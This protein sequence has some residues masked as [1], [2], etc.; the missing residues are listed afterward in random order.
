MEEL[1]CQAACQ[2][3]QAGKRVTVAFKLSNG[4]K[5]ESEERRQDDGEHRGDG[6][7]AEYHA[8]R[9]DLTIMPFRGWVHEDRNKRFAGTED[10]NREED[11]R[12]HRLLLFFMDMEMFHLVCMFMSMEG[13]VRV[14]V[15]M[16]MRPI[17]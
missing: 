12:R 8:H 4:E 16:V 17:H 3:R 2:Y 15:N 10:E 7:D 14:D 11:P 6:N 13:P 1:Y 9:R 5:G